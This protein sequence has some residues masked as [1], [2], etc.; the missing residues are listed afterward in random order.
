MPQI[1]RYPENMSIRQVIDMIRDIRGYQ[2]V[3]DRELY[4]AFGI[5]QFGD[6]KMRTL[7]GGTTQKVSATLPFCLIRQYL[8]WMNPQQVLIR[9]TKISKAINNLLKSIRK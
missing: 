3:E 2:G 4:D 5:E 8:S 6:K 1:G 7:S 9:E